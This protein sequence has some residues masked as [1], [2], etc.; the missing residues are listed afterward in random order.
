MVAFVLHNFIHGNYEEETKFDLVVEDPN[1]IPDNELHYVRGSD[2][3]N[4]H[5]YKG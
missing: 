2:T 5:L 1:C 3:S 4:E